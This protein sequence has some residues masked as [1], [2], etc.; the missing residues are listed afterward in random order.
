MCAFN[1]IS[2]HLSPGAAKGM[3]LLNVELKDT[4]DACLIRNKTAAHPNTLMHVYAHIHLKD[5]KKTCEIKKSSTI[6]LCFEFEISPKYSQSPLRG[7]TFGSWLDH[8]K[9][10]LIHVCMHQ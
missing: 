3:E 6:L 5:R 8:G 4:I 10:V 9:D 2:Q 7:R 1:R